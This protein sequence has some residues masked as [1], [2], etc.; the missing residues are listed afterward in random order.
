MTKQQNRVNYICLVLFGILELM[1]IIS[2]YAVNYYTKTRMGML[3]HVIYLNSKWEKTVPIPIIKWIVLCFIITLVIRAYLKYREQNVH[4]KINTIAMALTIGISG[5]TLY[6]LL[7]Y[8]KGMNRAYYILSFCFIL[9]TVL[10]NIL[11]HFI[12]SIK[13]KN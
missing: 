9:V 4:F 11:N 10:Q 5:W 13:S 7:F 8:N 3:R 6:F 1:V 2:A 12:L